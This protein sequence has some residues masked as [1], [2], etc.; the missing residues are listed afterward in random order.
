M[1]GIQASLL[2]NISYLA[3]WHVVAVVVVKPLKLKNY[4]E[5]CIK[6]KNYQFK[7]SPIHPD[8]WVGVMMPVG[9]LKLYQTQFV[10]QVN[11]FY[12]NV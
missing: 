4:M 10:S 5:K 7:I 3:W 8:S 9:T 2:A 6:Q 11:K 12:I 1:P